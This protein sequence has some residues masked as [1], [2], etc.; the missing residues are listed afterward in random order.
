MK[1]LEE[2]IHQN[3]MTL[4]DMFGL[5]CI[6]KVLLISTGKNLFWNSCMVPWGGSLI[7]KTIVFRSSGEEAGSYVAVSFYE[8][9]NN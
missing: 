8:P 3:H 9:P 7:Y 6:F 5:S 1:L 4:N 2:E